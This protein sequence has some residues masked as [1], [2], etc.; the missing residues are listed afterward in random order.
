MVGGNRNNRELKTSSSLY[1]VDPEIEDWGAMNSVRKVSFSS[2]RCVE[3]DAKFVGAVGLI[4]VCKNYNE[5]T[6]HRGWESIT[7]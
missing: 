1:T 7:N 2:R 5:L 6:I 3:S 4:C